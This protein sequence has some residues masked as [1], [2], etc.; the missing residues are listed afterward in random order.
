MVGGKESGRWRAGGLPAGM[1]SDL[2]LS[3]AQ[4][5]R[6][7][8]HIPTMLRIRPRALPCWGRNH[9][10][11]C[12]VGRAQLPL[13]VDFKHQP[14]HKLATQRYGPFGAAPMQPQPPGTC[15]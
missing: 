4:A 9:G 2:Q 14:H 5:V 8:S 3:A 10:P 12:R 1:Y 7:T 6:G 15:T 13:G 11:S